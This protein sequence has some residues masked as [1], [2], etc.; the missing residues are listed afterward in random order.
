[1]SGERNG[2][3][4]ERRVGTKPPKK[5]HCSAEGK[6]CNNT[7]TKRERAELLRSS[8]ALHIIISK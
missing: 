7:H 3:G 6:K 5:L 1:M 4:S 2:E 8:S